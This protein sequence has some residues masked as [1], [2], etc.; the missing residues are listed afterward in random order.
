M[1]LESV[2]G[3]ALGVMSLKRILGKTLEGKSSRE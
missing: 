1:N 3:S 2:E